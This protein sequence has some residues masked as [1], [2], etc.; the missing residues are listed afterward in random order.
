M[1]FNRLNRSFIG[2]LLVR[3]I[4]ISNLEDEKNNI[5]NTS[6]E[7]LEKQDTELKQKDFIIKSLEEKLDTVEG[8]V[9]SL[10]SNS[11]EVGYSHVFPENL[12]YN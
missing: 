6:K 11:L 12:F 4:T 10:E 7:E 8:Y 3:Q 2:F 5:L 9:H 1:S